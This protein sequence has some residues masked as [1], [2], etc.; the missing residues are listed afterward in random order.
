MNRILIS[1]LVL[2][3]ME[4]CDIQSKINKQDKAIAKIRQSFGIVTIDEKGMDKPVIE[5]DFSASQLITD[6]GLVYIKELS[7]LQ[8]LT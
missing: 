3:M 8:K 5:V 1:I 7:Q 6:D 2:C 4:G